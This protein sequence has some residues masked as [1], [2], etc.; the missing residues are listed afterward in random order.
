[1][2]TI[3]VAIIAAVAV[4]TAYD[5]KGQSELATGCLR[6]GTLRDLEFGDDPRR[7]E[8]ARGQETIKV[9]VISEYIN[10]G[11][12]RNPTTDL[13]EALVPL[14]ELGPFEVFGLCAGIQD[15]GIIVRPQEPWLHV[16]EPPVGD[17]TPR[18][19]LIRDAGSLE[20]A[21]RSGAFLRFTG[22]P[23]LHNIM[24]HVFVTTE[25]G[26]VL[27]TEFW[28]T[29]EMF[30]DCNFVGTLTLSAVE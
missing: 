18:T 15:I 10:V 19:S 8:C 24:R 29:T 5:A 12:A 13:E 4:T 16:G 25:S 17:L 23:T 27:R 3:I 22:N 11:L 7:G 2:R 14:A 28:F 21:T 1:M 26:A 6:N 30:D 9:P 20:F